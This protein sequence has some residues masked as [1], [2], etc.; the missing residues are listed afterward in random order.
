MGLSEI[1]STPAVTC[2]PD[3]TIGQVAGLMREHQIGSVLVVDDERVVGIVTD[4][5]LV[6]RALGAGKAA[7]APVDTVM[8]DEVIAVR[9][10]ATPVDAARQMAVRVCRRLPVLDED[11]RVLGVVSA[12]DLLR[13]DAT[14]LEHLGLLMSHERRQQRDGSRYQAA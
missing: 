6:L 1:G 13:H 10:S 8:S 2:G 4:R 9:D 11:G 14:M 12:D 3:A 7:D 5:D